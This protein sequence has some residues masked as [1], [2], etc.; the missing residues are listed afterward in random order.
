MTE[1]IRKRQWA[2]VIILTRIW[3]DLGFGMGRAGW[4][5]RR[6]SGELETCRGQGR[7]QGW[8][9]RKA[10]CISLRVALTA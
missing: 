3:R 5:E 7:L 4:G 6:R 1:G 10:V 8:K 9:R 2:G